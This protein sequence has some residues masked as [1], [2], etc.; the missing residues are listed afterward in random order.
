M[1]LFRKSDFFIFKVSNSNMQQSV[2][3]NKTF[4]FFVQMSWKKIYLTNTLCVCQVA[5]IS[6][7]SNNKQKS[8][9][10][11]KIGMLVFETLKNKK[12]ILWIVTRVSTR[13]YTVVIYYIWNLLK[14][15]KFKFFPS[16]S[17]SLR[18]IPRGLSCL[19]KRW[20][21]EFSYSGYKFVIYYIW[22]LLKYR[23][24]I[25][26]LLL[27]SVCVII[28]AWPAMFEEKVSYRVFL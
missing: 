27:L 12:L 8:F 19:K 24:L 15:Q 26:F 20:A 22:N 13:D 28:R 7:R 10:P 18:Y 5:G 2:F 23:N 21:I 11:K 3:L 25:V 16:S 6:K 17:F 4:L 14:V 1:L 9:V